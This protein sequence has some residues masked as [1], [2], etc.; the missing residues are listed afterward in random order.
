MKQF[1]RGLAAVALALIS[2]GA[3]AAEHVHMNRTVETLEAGDPVFGLF[4]SDFSLSNA[5]ALS[6]SELGK[7]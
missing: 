6:R 5:M 1:A 7:K 2:I 4:T 3:A